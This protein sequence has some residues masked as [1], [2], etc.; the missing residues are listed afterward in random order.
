MLNQWFL[1]DDA[2][3]L[4]R[5]EE[6]EQQERVWFAWVCRLHDVHS[7][8]QSPHSAAVLAIAQ[9]RWT[10][11]RLA[12]QREARRPEKATPQDGEGLTPD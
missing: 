2:R 11:A 4:G 8:D 3:V 9:R 7:G 12:L 10:Q 6:L 5:F 1:D